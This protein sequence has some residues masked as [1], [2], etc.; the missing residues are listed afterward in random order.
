[1]SQVP[2]LIQGLL[3][4]DDGALRGSRGHESP[5]DSRPEL[6]P[7]PTTQRGR[8][9]STKKNKTELTGGA[10]NGCQAARNTRPSHPGLAF[11]CFSE[12][13]GGG[14]SRWAVCAG[15][16]SSGVKLLGLKLCSTVSVE[17]RRPPM[18]TSRRAV[19]KCPVTPARVSAKSIPPFTGGLW[20][21]F[22]FNF[23]F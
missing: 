5:L 22:C 10:V 12:T 20:F 18:S 17:S 19:L 2:L 16:C 21:S 23:D 7:P 1:M 3:S 13:L 9:E 4:R 8:L 15:S 11:E 6:P 14:W